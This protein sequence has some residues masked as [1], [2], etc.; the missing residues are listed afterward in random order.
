MINI[1]GL[2]SFTVLLAIGQVLFKKVALGIRGLPL[3]DGFSAALRDPVLYAALTLY[4]L[5]T[6]LWIW[7]LSRVPLS[8]AYPWV[9]V[10]SAIVPLLAWYIYNERIAPV[11]W[12]GV[13]L[14]MAGLFLTQY[15]TRNL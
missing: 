10:G 2:A 15:G 13:A 3:D 11:F 7:L 5:T 12:V 14:I 4:G 6:L 8:Q 9:A 1:F